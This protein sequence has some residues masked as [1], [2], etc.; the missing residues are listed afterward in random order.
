MEYQY[1]RL[2]NEFNPSTYDS[3]EEEGADG[4]EQE[5]D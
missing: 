1:I 2:F 5:G 3:S 4:N